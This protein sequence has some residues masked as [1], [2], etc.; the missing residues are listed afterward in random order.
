MA[1]KTL[2]IIETCMVLAQGWDNKQNV[3]MAMHKFVSGWH[4]LVLFAEKDPRCEV[5]CP[6]MYE[7]NLS[8]KCIGG[9]TLAPLLDS[10]ILEKRLG[11]HGDVCC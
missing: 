6:Y 2:Q 4:T 7:L 11:H 8:V 5:I 9:A 3:K 10:K 1:V